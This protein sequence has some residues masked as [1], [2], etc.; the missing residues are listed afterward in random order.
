[1]GGIEM[2]R[3]QRVLIAGVRASGGGQKALV[4]GIHN[5][6][7]R[8]RIVALGVAIGISA[9][10]GVPATQAATFTVNTAGHY[11]DVDPGDGSC[12]TANS[13]C[14][15]RAAVA[16]ANA[17]D[18]GPAKV[19]VIMFNYY[20]GHYIKLSGTELSITDELKV[21]GPGADQLTLDADADGDGIGDSRIFNATD[22]TSLTTISGL[23]LVNGKT[24][25]CG[26]SIYAIKDLVLEN[27][28]VR[29]SRAADGGAVCVYATFGGS[30]DPGS[31]TVTGT[32]ISNNFATS[33]GGGIW[34][35]GDVIVTDSR[36]VGNITGGFGGGISQKVGEMVIADSAIL[37][38]VAS[39]LDGG[40]IRSRG[41]L[42]TLT[43]SIVSDNS[44]HNRGG[45]VFVHGSLTVANSVVSNNEALDGGGVKV[46]YG[47]AKFSDSTISGN[48][49][50]ESG[51]GI[52]VV[53]G[54]LRVE[55]SRIFDNQGGTF[56]GGPNSAGGG[57]ILAVGNPPFGITYIID[58]TIHDN[59][60]ASIG[61]GMTAKGTLVLVNT[62]VSR[63][64]A[65]GGAGINL[66]DTTE[67]DLWHSTVTENEVAFHGGGIASLDPDN[68]IDL[69]DTIVAGN[70]S[71]DSEVSVSGPDIYL[72]QVTLN[73]SLVGVV[74]DG[75]SAL[76]IGPGS[77]VGTLA[78]PRDPKLVPLA[79][80]GGATLTH[81]LA[82]GSPALDAGD[83]AFLPTDDPLYDQRGSGY[84]R[85]RNG[86]LDMGA[87]EGIDDVIFADG[88]ELP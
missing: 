80:N 78:N 69:Y 88:F 59:T 49:A 34:V 56:L 38:N 21:I 68:V 6:L 26:G 67:A 19:D 17:N 58:S 74:D 57:G 77:L 61:G 31:I 81:G 39:N 22:A 4:V 54:N 72:G 16:E 35:W 11:P 71:F 18:N 2:K 48:V 23:T 66:G 40:G 13:S 43:D 36:I 79:D 51:G 85:V 46:M 55:S 63:N 5:A 28:V 50:D 7:V 33:S 14:S 60:S 20:A 12:W 75:P 87:F 25:G 44:A 15:L 29:D 41:D 64:F 3:M 45:G 27:A 32:T 53:E 65:F 86:R 10:A 37:D 70:H 82:P 47:V 1:M 76:T 8:S 52:S 62:T 9:A 84:P 42:V 83:P 30:I 24:T 73:Y